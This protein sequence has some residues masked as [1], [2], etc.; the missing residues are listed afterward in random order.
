MCRSLSVMMTAVAAAI[1]QDSKRGVENASEHKSTIMTTFHPLLFSPSQDSSTRAAMLNN[2]SLHAQIPFQDVRI[3]M[4]QLYLH[5][6]TQFIS[7]VILWSGESEL[8][9]IWSINGIAIFVFAVLHTFNA[10]FNQNH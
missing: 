3:W 8:S 1:P 9:V 2:G 7:S 10:E 6:M 4:M 5:S